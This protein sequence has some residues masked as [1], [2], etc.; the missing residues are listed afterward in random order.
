M[1]LKN[2]QMEEDSSEVGIN[3]Y[4]KCTSEINEKGKKYSTNGIRVFNL[5][6]MYIYIYNQTDSRWIKEI[7]VFFKQTQKE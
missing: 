3:F 2:H 7:C 6:Y 1:D 5:L 4:H